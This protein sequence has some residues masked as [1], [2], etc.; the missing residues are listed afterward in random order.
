MVK[1]FHARYDVIVVGGGNAGFTAATTAS[2]HGAR[3]LLID[4]APES[5]KGGNT[6]YTAG[7]YRYCFEGIDD[8]K[9]IL[10][11]VETGSRGLPED[12]LRNID[13]TGYSEDDFM[14]DMRKVTKGRCDPALSRKLVS[15]SRSAIQWISDNGGKFVLSFNRQ[16]Y[17]IKD[18]F[19]FWGGMATVFMGGGK[20]LVDWHLETA[21]RHGVEIW[22]NTPAVSL[23]TDEASG[24]S[25]VIGI[26]VLKDGRRLSLSAAGGVILACGG[27]QSDPSL[28]AKYLGPGWDLAHVRGSPFN[29]GDGHRLARTI[30]AKTAGNYSGCHS[31]CWD[32]NSPRDGG[33][34][35]I[36]NQFTKSGYPLGLM[37]NCD[38]KRF[39]DE[40]LD[41]RNY[42]YAIFGVEVLK[43]PSSKAF[44][45]WDA[46]GS[47]WLRKEE[48]ADDVTEHSSRH[49]RG[50]GGKADT[51]WSY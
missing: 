51:A 33:D 11:E 17:K 37:V 30:G 50:T 5:E 27:F 48:Y 4:K 9:P 3:V 2:Q 46:D 25:R 40:G 19:V 29:T 6:Y 10:Y 34:R 21:K 20:A 45:I 15:Q 8:L 28:R 35:V 23:T 38:G 13:V 47:R 14:N 18:R 31:T 16:A 22:W 12:L 42:T 1:Y 49:V 44:Q 24:Y 41:L 36:T 43:Q 26:E 39:V 32:A 7:A